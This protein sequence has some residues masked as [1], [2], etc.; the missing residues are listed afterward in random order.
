MLLV[1]LRWAI[2]L[3]V[4]HA[5]PLPCELGL[6]AVEKLVE[7]ACEDESSPRPCSSMTSFGQATRDG[8]K[9]LSARSD[10]RRRGSTQSGSEGPELGVI[11]GGVFGA[12]GGLAVIGA[13]F[14]AWWSIRKVER[15]HAAHEMNASP[16]FGAGVTHSQLVGQKSSKDSRTSSSNKSRQSKKKPSGAKWQDPWLARPSRSPRTAPVAVNLDPPA[17]GPSV[18]GK[19][20]PDEDQTS[21]SSAVPLHVMVSRVDEESKTIRNDL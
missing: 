16:S 3:L 7:A 20:V 9:V 4:V 6:C 19:P 1:G 14:Y 15:N 8:D 13:I 2:L 21:D 5:L 11:L 10:I 12:L 18:S 17:G